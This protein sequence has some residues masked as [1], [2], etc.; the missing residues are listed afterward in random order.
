LVIHIQELWA[1][2]L[3]AI[4]DKISKPSFETWLKTTEAI[5]LREDILVVSTPNDF[6]RDWLESRYADLVRDALK[7]V[8]GSPL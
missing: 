1:K 2:T 7:E 4:Q 8:T 5:N 6:A 3:D